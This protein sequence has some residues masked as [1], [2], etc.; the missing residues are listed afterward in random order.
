[1]SQ[2]IETDSVFHSESENHADD[3]DVTWLDLPQIEPRNKR[4]LRSEFKMPKWMQEGIQ[5]DKTEMRESGLLV[6]VID[7]KPWEKLNE[8][9]KQFIGFLKASRWPMS[10]FLAYTADLDD[11]VREHIN[12]TLS[13]LESHNIYINHESI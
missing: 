1:M 10:D 4:V 2:K 9:M 3:T 5:K 8:E 6:K 12:S 13:F 7:I 11:E